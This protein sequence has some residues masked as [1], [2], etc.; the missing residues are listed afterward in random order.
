MELLARVAQEEAVRARLQAVGDELEVRHLDRGVDVGQLGIVVPLRDLER[1]RRAALGVA[2][3][4]VALRLAGVDHV[5]RALL[6][7]ELDRPGLTRLRR[8]HAA[9]RVEPVWD[10]PVLGGDRRE[11]LLDRMA[12][13]EA[14]QLR[15]GVLLRPV[16]EVEPDKARLDGLGNRQLE[17]TVIR[18]CRLDGTA[19]GSP[20]SSSPPQAVTPTTK[21]TSTAA[22]TP[23][24][25]I[26]PPPSS[27]RF[28]ARSPSPEVSAGAPRHA[29]P[30]TRTAWR[31]IALEVAHRTNVRCPTRG[32]DTGDCGSSRL[33][34]A[35]DLLSSRPSSRRTGA[36][37]RHRTTARGGLLLLLTALL[38]AAVVASPG[39]APK[40]GLVDGQPIVF[41]LIGNYPYSDELRR[42]RAR[43]AA[44]P[45]S[46]SRTCRGARPVVAAEAGRVR[47]HTTS[48]ARRLHALPLRPQR[49]D[50]HLYPSQQRPHRAVRGPWRAASSGPRTPSRTERGSRPASRSRG[51]GTRAT[52]RETTTSTSRCIPATAPTSTPIRT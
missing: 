35:D 17:P 23:D 10:L 3:H 5:V 9:L 2:L 44:T 27:C 13:V 46:T 33:L 36:M 28:P 25:T 37:T 20:P 39:A 31:G 49:H 7:H 4:V 30:W 38:G 15:L 42:R 43:T 24:L 12:V 50:I 1:R 19:C 8:P 51:T 18:W 47:W 45:G 16:L 14:E 22:T 21:T 34:L 40:P 29:N 26:S 48:C 52:P 11:R 41:P 32:Q 6:E